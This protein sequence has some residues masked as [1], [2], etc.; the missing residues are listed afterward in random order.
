LGGLLL[1]DRHTFDLDQGLAFLD[2]FAQCYV[3]LPNDAF[4]L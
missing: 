2:P 3:N 4:H 1:S